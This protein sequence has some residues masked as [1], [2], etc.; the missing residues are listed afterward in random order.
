[1][2]DGKLL[3]VVDGGVSLA[4][5]FVDNTTGSSSGANTLDGNGFCP[6][7]FSKPTATTLGLPVSVSQH[8]GGGWPGL[9]PV[10]AGPGYGRFVR[11]RNAMRNV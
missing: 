6:V 11:R 3:R 7:S 8:N 4:R 5:P 2:L 9:S 10:G 1:M